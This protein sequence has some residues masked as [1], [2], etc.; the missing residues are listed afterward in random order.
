MA[1]PAHSLKAPS[2][3]AAHLCIRP[4][5]YVT[6][7]KLSPGRTTDEAVQE[8]GR[9]AGTPCSTT[10]GFCDVLETARRIEMPFGRRR[11]AS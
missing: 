2:V 8:Q 11:Y 1:E 4:G 7:E 3:A 10:L 9:L 6:V 5:P